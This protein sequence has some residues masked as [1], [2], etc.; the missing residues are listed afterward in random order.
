MINLIKIERESDEVD[1]FFSLVDDL[2]SDDI[3]QK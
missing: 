1:R 3:I 2:D